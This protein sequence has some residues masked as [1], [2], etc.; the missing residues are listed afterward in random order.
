MFLQAV[1]IC[2][3][4]KH[5][6]D[7][8]LY[9]QQIR[10]LNAKSY[11]ILKTKYRMQNSFTLD[12]HSVLFRL[13]VILFIVIGYINCVSLFRFANHYEN[14]MVLQREPNQA[15]L[16]GY[17]ETGSLVVLTVAGRT[18]AA[19][20]GSGNANKNIWII[21]LLPEK[22][23]GPFDLNAWSKVN[24]ERVN[25]TLND[26]M[27]GDVWFCSGQSNM[28]FTVSMADDSALEIAEADNYPQVR[29]LTVGKYASKQPV[30]EISKD[31]IHQ[32]WSV[33]S[34]A[35]VG[36]GA[37]NYFS[38]VCWMYGRRL[39]DLLNV[40][41]GLISSAYGGSA[42]EAWSSPNALSK[43]S[44][45]TPID[46][47]DASQL[48]W[49]WN[50]MLHPFLRMTIYGV[51][52]YQGE[53]NSQKVRNYKCEF[54]EMIKD[55]RLRWHQASNGTTSLNF[56]FGFVQLS[57]LGN[58]LS[59]YKN[60]NAMVHGFPVIRWQQTAEYGYVPNPKLPNTFMA[61]ALD[62]PD[63]KSPFLGIHP[64]H[65]TD[66]AYRLVLG[67]Q[68]I[69]YGKAVD[70]TGPIIDRIVLKYVAVR[71][72]DFI[73]YYKV[74]SVPKMLDIRSKKGFE[75]VF[76]N[77]YTKKQ[78]KWLPYNITNSS[79]YTVSFRVYKFDELEVTAV[80]YNWRQQPCQ[81]KKCAVYSGNL[82]SPPYIQYAPF[83]TYYNSK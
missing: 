53:S 28:G 12:M 41:I 42:I 70:W 5:S 63:N 1:S 44:I 60:A 33:A 65:K 21:K 80:R 6:C 14:H 20:V 3:N 9:T 57:T 45:S 77:K 40:P 29:I 61:V 31:K 82:P 32:H 26:V 30:D 71:T 13:A 23:G 22:P 58:D 79:R 73:V 56:P 64:R 17:G 69:A 27:F 72:F 74:K 7:F 19:R 52:W 38:A 67:A 75:V 25:I 51:I 15:L 16:W 37:W 2:S 18:Y 24:G 81:F 46:D 8:Y 47:N 50:G 35:T 36:G 11:A 76:T 10:L 62:L 43:C 78:T 4:K 48:S 55:W 66:V 68:A 54:P 39:H 34:S 83:D 59:S 49:F